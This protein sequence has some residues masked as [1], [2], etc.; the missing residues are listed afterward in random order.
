MAVSLTALV[1]AFA[2]I[3]AWNVA[4]VDFL[5]SAVTRRDGR[6]LALP[7]L[8]LVGD[9]TRHRAAKMLVYGRTSATSA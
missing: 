8:T 3:V 1:I 9:V 4:G 7:V 5:S 2:S 6:T